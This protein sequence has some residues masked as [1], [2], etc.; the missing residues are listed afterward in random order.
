MEERIGRFLTARNT[1]TWFNVLPQIVEAYN[2]T[3]HTAIEM[4]PIDVNRKNAPLLFDYLEQKRS[5]ISRQRKTKFNI[6]DIVR[7]PV[8][9]DKTN[10]FKKGYTPNWTQELYQ[11]DKIE[12]GTHVPSFF[13]INLKGKKIAR[14]F[15]ENELNLVLSFSEIS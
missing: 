15:Y 12:F 3:L 9:A 8:N 5:Q 14:R 11:I 13:I 1:R 7:I 10:K 4:K 2:N 6:G